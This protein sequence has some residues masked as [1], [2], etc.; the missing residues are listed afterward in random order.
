MTIGRWRFDSSGIPV[1]IVQLATPIVAGWLIAIA[2]RFPDWEV[3]FWVWAIV[4]IALWVAL[5]VL[6]KRDLRIIQSASDTEVSDLR[7]AM[8][9][10]LQPLIRLISEMPDKPEEERDGHLKAI[11]ENAVMASATLLMAHVERARA[12]IYSMET[13]GSALRV[14]AYGGRGEKPGEFV[15]GAPGANAALQR[16][17][18]GKSLIVKDWRVDPPEGWTKTESD[19]SSFVSVPIISGDGYAYGMVSIDSPKAESFFDTEKH[20]VTVVAELLAVA[21]ALA[22]PAASRG[23]RANV[24]DTDRI[25]P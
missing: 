19:W 17:K 11:A 10:A 3:W 2:K 9:D 18:S 16:V 4:L 7:V 6:V 15:R 12:N 13:D 25:G 1:Q 21:F 8:K 20:T 22:Y 24:G 14:L 23:L 5:Q